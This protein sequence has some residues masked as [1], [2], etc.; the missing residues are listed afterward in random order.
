MKSKLK[1]IPALLALMILV[2]AGA[3]AETAIE[4]GD[5][6][7]AAILQADASPDEA[8]PGETPAPEPDETPVPIEETPLP[9]LR[10]EFHI[11]YGEAGAQPT[12]YTGGAF[13]LVMEDVAPGTAIDAPA[14]PDSLEVNGAAYLPADAAWR[15]SGGYG[16][17]ELS[18]V[19]RSMSFCVTY[20]PAPREAGYA[21]RHYWLGDPDVTICEDVA[22][23]AVIGDV[24]R[25]ETPAE[26]PGYAFLRTGKTELVIGEDESLNEIA[27][28]YSR[29]LTLTSQ[30]A[31]KIYDGTALSCNE[32]LL[33]GTLAEGD[34]LQVLLGGSIT[35]V[36][37]AE[38]SFSHVAI[39]RGGEDVTRSGE[40]LVSLQAGALTVL[41]APLEITAGSA[42]KRRD[43]TPLSC[44]QWALS[45]G[46][47]GEGHSVASI[48]LTGSRT[49]LGESPNLPCDAVIVDENGADVT[50]NYAISYCPGT[51]TV[52][53]RLPL[54][55]I[56]GS[57]AKTYDGA[58]LRDAG[59]SCNG[60]QEGD[61]L[62][63]QVRGSISSVGSAQNAIEAVS[64]TRDGRD[65]SAEYEIMLREGTLT[66][67]PIEIEIT[68]G[69]ATRAYDGTAL[70]CDD[71]AL[72]HGA[73]LAGHTLRGVC[74]TG[75]CTEVGWAQ[76]VPGGARIVDEGG[77]DVTENYDIRYVNGWLRVTDNPDGTDAP[78]R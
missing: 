66:V 1:W 47:L 67:R 38:N 51:L 16:A 19:Q 41:P 50:A 55:V 44:S 17:E 59:F 23:T 43:G 14:I 21:V 49:E 73:L 78:R 77:L 18:D 36:G 9:S 35:D 33:T 22:G 11:Y 70:T 37:T 12:E 46:S 57:A 2:T 39:L 28:Y 62:D 13:P 3:L 65:V 31:E 60:L 5:A 30:S 34:A 56:A 24:L 7:F 74:V 20:L 27:L 32:V 40:Y 58:P 64:V 6:A 48:R 54:I 45:G 15:P 42:Y 29:E 25:W 75:S 72:T 68:A 76:N 8:V 53:E 10:V 61:V 52:T 4:G 63:A 71:W 26:V 69:S